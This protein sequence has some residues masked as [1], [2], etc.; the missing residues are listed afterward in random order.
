MQSLAKELG[1]DLCTKLVISNPLRHLDP[2]RT[3]EE[4]EPLTFLRESRAFYL[5]GCLLRLRLRFGLWLLCLRLR[6]RMLH[7]L[8]GKLGKLCLLCGRVPFPP[9]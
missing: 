9:F 7:G 1:Y 8:P 6:L 2:L 3:L 5:L 4:R